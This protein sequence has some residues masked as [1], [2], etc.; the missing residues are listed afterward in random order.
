VAPTLAS[1]GVGFVLPLTAPRERVAPLSA[2]TKREIDALGL[3]LMSKAERRFT[4]I[5]WICVFGLTACW[6]YSLYLACGSVHTRL[7]FVYGFGGYFIGV[8]LS[9]VREAV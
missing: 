3:T 9:E 1:A 2:S 8:I 6:A 4:E 5:V 7:H